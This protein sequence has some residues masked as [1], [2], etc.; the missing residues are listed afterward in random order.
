[1]PVH[2]VQ[3]CSGCCM[4]C[5]WPSQH[6]CHCSCLDLVAWQLGHAKQ[7]CRTAECRLQLPAP[8]A[9]TMYKQNQSSSRL[10]PTPHCSRS[11]A[12]THNT[13]SWEDFWAGQSEA[14]CL[15][16]MKAVIID[17]NVKPVYCSFDPDLGSMKQK[18]PNA[19]H[20]GSGTCV[21]SKRV[22]PSTLSRGCAVDR[23]LDISCTIAGLKASPRLPCQSQA[24]PAPVCTTTL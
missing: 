9:Y 2:A 18:D 20:S 7:C 3:H 11:V 22:P 1:M 4:C 8:P 6:Y 12:K 19:A 21:M 10:I 24:A 14:D 15:W 23:K 5:C 17:N 13:V 16:D